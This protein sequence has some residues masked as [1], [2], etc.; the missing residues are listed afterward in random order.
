[1][2]V[3]RDTAAAHGKR[4]WY[5]TRMWRTLGGSGPWGALA[6]ACSA[7]SQPGQV[8]GESARPANG[9]AGALASGDRSGTAAEEATER[10]GATNSGANDVA[11]DSGGATNGG[12]TNGGTAAQAGGDGGTCGLPAPPSMSQECQSF[13]EIACAR[14]ME[15]KPQFPNHNDGISDLELG[16]CMRSQAT[17][18]HTLGLPGSFLDA[19]KLEECRSRVETA[20]CALI[21]GADVASLGM[22]FCV[23][24]GTRGEGESCEEHHQCSSRH[25]ESGTSCRAGMR[26]ESAPLDTARDEGEAPLD[27]QCN[28]RF[29]TVVE[30]VCSLTGDGGVGEPCPCDAMQGLACECGEEFCDGEEGICQPPPVLAEGAQCGS[31]PK[32]ISSVH[33]Q[34]DDGLTCFRTGVAMPTCVAIAAEG[35]SCEGNTFNSNCDGELSCVGPCQATNSWMWT[36]T[37]TP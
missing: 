6:L 24:S 25:C 37:C 15:C 2:A 12:A 7:S 28:N 18:C 20:S 36:G 27:G 1:M 23:R 29:L 8:G 19:A 32:A 16:R 3:E 13:A 10:S 5:P 34:C 35:E 21:R 4:P 33:G 14:T 30:G 26:N 9:G 17:H 31:H 22:S 11:V